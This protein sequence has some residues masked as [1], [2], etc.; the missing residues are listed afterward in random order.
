MGARRDNDLLSDVSW[1]DDH[2]IGPTR[3]GE[4]GGGGHGGCLKSRYGPTALGVV[5]PALLDAEPAVV[6]PVGA[7]RVATEPVLRAV[8][9]DAPSGE[10]NGVVDRNLVVVRNDAGPI[11]RLE[12]VGVDPTT[13]G[14]T[15]R[16]FFHDGVRAVH[17]PVLIDEKSSVCAVLHGE[18]T[19]SRHAVA[20]GR[21][22]SARVVC[23]LVLLAGD[24]RDAVLVNPLERSR[25]RTAVARTG[26]IRAT[27]QQNLNCGN[28]IAGFAA[29]QPF[30]TVGNRGHGPVSPARATPLGDVLV[31]VCGAVA[32]ARDVTPVELR[33][34]SI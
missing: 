5:G 13:D 29:L 16:D 21:F 9:C 30:E 20:A 3:C 4:A 28:K 10:R 32:H 17:R 8:L 15:G 18:A 31:Q 2:L 11:P 19:L 7:P 26:H 12:R 1:H 27:V 14:S 24:L 22:R 33:R 23:S 6:A 25:N 34:E